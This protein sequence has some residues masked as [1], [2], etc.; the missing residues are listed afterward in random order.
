MGIALNVEA[1]HRLNRYDAALKARFLTYLRSPVALS[2]YR[3]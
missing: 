1:A 3:V 2:G